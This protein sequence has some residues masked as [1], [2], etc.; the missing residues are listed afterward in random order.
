LRFHVFVGPEHATILDEYARLTGRPFVPPAWAFLHW[1]WRDTLDAGPPALLDGVAMN[2]EVST[3]SPC[4]RPSASRPA[5]TTSTG[6]S[7][8]L[9]APTSAARASSST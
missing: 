5:S 4:T 1:R 9:T 2:A 3:T 8:R 6:P 7:S